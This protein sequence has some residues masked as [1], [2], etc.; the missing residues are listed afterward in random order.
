MA[1]LIINKSKRKMI[2]SL[3]YFLILVFMGEIISKLKK[4]LAKIS[5][6]FN[7]KYTIEL[8]KIAFMLVLRV[9]IKNL[10]LTNRLIDDFL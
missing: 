3:M 1:L 9:F 2:I 10:R 5:D 8:L 7:P 4:T 6:I